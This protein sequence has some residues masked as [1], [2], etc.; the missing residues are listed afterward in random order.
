MTLG[1]GDCDL[2]LSHASV[3]RRHAQIKVHEE[4]LEV[5]DLGS[6]NGTF[7][8]GN[9]VMSTRIQAGDEII[10]GGVRLRLEEALDGDLR[11][12]L[13]LRQRS[14]EKKGNGRRSATFSFIPTDSFAAERLPALLALLADHAPVARVAQATGA[15]IL[16]T[17]RDI[18]LSISCEHGEDAGVL[19]QARAE[20][21]RA[22]E[23]LVARRGGV[24]VS[25]EAPDPSMQA[26]LAPFAETAALLVSLAAG[27]DESQPETSLVQPPRLPEPESVDTV[28]RRIYSDAATIASGDVEVLICGESGTGKEVLARYIHEASPRRNGPFVALNCAALPRDLLE[29]ELFG[30]ERRVATGVDERPGKFE[31]ACG[32]TLFLDEIGDMDLG[33]QASILRVLQEREVFRVGGARPRDADVRVI[34]ATNR[35]VTD[36][37]ADGHFREDLYY[38]IAAWEVTIPPLR[39]RRGDIANLAAYFLHRAGRQRHAHVAGISKNAIEAL[40]KYSWPGNIRQLQKE[41]ERAALFVREGL[42]NSTHLS[43]KI[44]K[45]VDGR[46]SLNLDERLELCQRNVIVTAL[47]LAQGEVGRAATALGLSRST[48]YRRLKELGIDS[49]KIVQT[50]GGS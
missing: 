16:A 19:Y 40:V 37:M 46:P 21:Q 4:G 49:A 10:F 44:L 8:D 35:E 47:Q 30:I 5:V 24:R 32:G 26:I 11:T 38:R 28:I 42:L 13:Q 48:L 3:S 50:S 33:T 43:P 14:V 1:R 18:G 7:V 23:P 25:L 9:R 20:D 39:E 27:T 41:V 17:F 6:S 29:A 2:V 45:E 31:M 36:L 34:A 22:A 15:A 12:G